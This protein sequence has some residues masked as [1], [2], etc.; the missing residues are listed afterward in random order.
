[1]SHHILVSHPHPACLLPITHPF[2]ADTLRRKVDVAETFARHAPI[3]YTPD[4]YDMNERSSHL[5]M[6]GEFAK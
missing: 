2:R 3:R 5:D 4:D 6:M 1:M